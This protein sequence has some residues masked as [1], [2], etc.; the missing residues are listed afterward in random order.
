M[1]CPAPSQRRTS[2]RPGKC[3]PG[4]RC[5][6]LKRL[7][8]D[9]RDVSQ[10]HCG[11]QHRLGR[12]APSDGLQQVHEQPNGRLTAFPAVAHKPARVRR[13]AGPHACVGRPAVG[14]LA[15]QAEPIRLFIKPEH[16]AWMS[17]PIQF[18]R[19]CFSIGDGEEQAIVCRCG[20]RPVAA[21]M[22]S[23]WPWARAHRT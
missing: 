16:L 5:G 20:G 15:L 6:R 22:R 12:R 8:L 2:A 9:P 3:R 1:R 14:Q 13:A 10:L 23:R 21:S 19:A 11:H 4:H 18:S 7:A 17:E